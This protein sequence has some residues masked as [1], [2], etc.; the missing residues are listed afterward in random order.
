[1]DAHPSAD[2]AHSNGS[3]PQRAASKAAFPLTPNTWSG[4]SRDQLV[5]RRRAAQRA[6]RLACEHAERASQ[7]L[8]RALTAPHSPAVSTARERLEH[9]LRGERQARTSY[10]RVAQE[11]GALLSSLDRTGARL[12]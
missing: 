9:A 12:A 4:E 11:T 10:Y 8:S 1:M 7:Y 6:W 2:S 3:G 5:A